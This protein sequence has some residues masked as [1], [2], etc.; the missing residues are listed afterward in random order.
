MT[1]A[2][3]R[4]RFRR[5]I[6]DIKPAGSDESDLLFTDDSINDFIDEAHRVFVAETFY[7]HTLLELDVVATEADIALP[8]TFLDLR[9]NAG[10]LVNAQRVVR[11]RALY[12][13]VLSDD[14]GGMTSVL[15]FSDDTL[16]TPRFFSLDLEFNTLRLFPTPAED[17]ILRLSVYLEPDPIDFA[18]QDD[19][20][21]AFV[22]TNKHHVLCLLDGMK[23]IA[24]R[25]QDVDVY[26]PRQAE[27][28]EASFRRKIAD[29]RSERMRRRCRPQEI[30]YGGL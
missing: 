11:K 14:Y 7:Y 4:D 28:W 1:P 30:L 16:A 17:D 15:Q 29:V 23:A 12:E 25:V 24:Y 3:L 27:R 22:M 5:D 9:G 21:T 26:D 6:D 10:E 2:Q 8:D 13:G 19:L 20:S 18:T